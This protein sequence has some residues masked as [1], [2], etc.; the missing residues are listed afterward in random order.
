VTAQG[1]LVEPKQARSILER[2]AHALDECALKQLGNL[3]HGP[4]RNI[5]SARAHQ[6]SIR[7]RPHNKDIGIIVD[8]RK[9]ARDRRNH[10]RRSYI[11][12]LTNNLESSGIGG[13]MTPSKQ[14]FG[15]IS[16]ERAD[17]ANSSFIHN[18]GMMLRASEGAWRMAESKPNIFRAKSIG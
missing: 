13:E 11:G 7:A 9:N 6:K 8:R 16:G 5:A 3:G 12:L 1:L 4:H 17:R 18:V 10:L 14:A 2:Q 15:M